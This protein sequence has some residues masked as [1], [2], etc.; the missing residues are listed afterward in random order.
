M[1]FPTI[2]RRTACGAIPFLVA[3]VSQLTRLEPSD[4]LATGNPGTSAVEIA[5]PSGSG[6]ETEVEIDGVGTPVAGN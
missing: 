3:Y 1:K 2:A 4:I 6:P 5:R